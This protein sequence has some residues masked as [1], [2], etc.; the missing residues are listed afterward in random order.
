MSVE[1]LTSSISVPDDVRA[2]ARFRGSSAG[3]IFSL[4]LNLDPSEFA[5]PRSRTAEIES[6]ADA[7]RQRY[8]DDEEHRPLELDSPVAR[9]VERVRS[10]LESEFAPRGARAVATFVSDE[11]ELFV[12]IRLHHPVQG[13]VV[14]AERPFVRPLLE[15]PPLLDG[16]FVLMVNRRTARLLAGREGALQEVAGFTDAVHGRHDQG[17]WSQPRY[18]RHIE[19][20][21]KD[22]V[23]HACRE[24]FEH[25]RQEAVDHLVLAATE[26]VRPLVEAALHPDLSRVLA[27]QVTADIEV[28]KPEELTPR[29]LDLAIQDRDRSDSELLDQLGAG[30]AHG[31]GAAA[32]LERVLDAL[33]L[34]S[35]EVLLACPDL[36]GSAVSCPTC[37]WLGLGE[38]ICPVDD[39]QT[40][41]RDDVL[42]VAVEA[43]LDQGAAVRLLDRAEVRSNGCVAA[44]LRFTPA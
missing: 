3:G 2:L 40:A 38:A 20:Q 36:S 29:V 1:R 39:S 22:H 4:Y 24:V 5:V 25:S 7:A 12:V 34:R 26:E 35:V 28:T 10:Y 32:G 9:T 27:G 17:G 33:N 16:W 42:E 15:G 14:L 30:L 19:K 8:T 43:A 31:E 41:A 23:E 37:G 11:P 18:Q 44:L 13:R 21:V 6:L